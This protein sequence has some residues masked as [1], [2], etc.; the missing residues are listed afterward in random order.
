MHAVVPQAEEARQDPPVDAPE[1]MTWT[2]TPVWTPSLQNCETM[3]FF[4]LYLVCSTL[5]Q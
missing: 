5:L 4:G 1:N 3:R 2:K